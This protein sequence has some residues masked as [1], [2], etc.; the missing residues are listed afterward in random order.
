M[1]KLKYRAC[2]HSYDSMSKWYLYVETT[3][4]N[5]VICGSLDFMQSWL[6]TCAVWSSG[7]L[8]RL[9]PYLKMFV[10]GM[11]VIWQS[12]MLL[13]KNEQFWSLAAGLLE[14]KPLSLIESL[15]SRKATEFSVISQMYFRAGWKE[16]TEVINRLN[17][18]LLDEVAPTLSSMQRL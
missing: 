6:R 15:M 2:R 3:P 14:D 4:Q 18:S 17:S 7:S 8:F 1:T 11:L 9:A 13:S 5:T 10:T 12:F 16:L